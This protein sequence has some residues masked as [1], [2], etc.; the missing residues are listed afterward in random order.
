MRRDRRAGV[1]TIKLSYPL[2]DVSTCGSRACSGRRDPATGLPHEMLAVSATCRSA[3][4]RKERQDLVAM[5]SH[6]LKNPLTAVLGFAE[7]LRALPGPD[8]ERPS[9]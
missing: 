1:A 4:A 6:D 2:Q 3:S 9:S 8:A 7:I 5:L